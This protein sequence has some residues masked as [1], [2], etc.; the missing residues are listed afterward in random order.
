MRTRVLADVGERFDEIGRRHEEPRLADRAE[1]RYPLSGFERRD[2]LL[3]TARTE[4]EQAEGGKCLRAGASQAELDVARKRALGQGVAFVSVSTSCLHPGQNGRRRCRLG[5]L[6]RLVE[7]PERLARLC[8]RGFPVPGAEVELRPRKERLREVQQE[9]GLT[10]QGDR[11][12]RHLARQ[13]VLLEPD[14]RPRDAERVRVSV[15]CFRRRLHRGER[16]VASSRSSGDGATHAQGH[17]VDEVV[18]AGRKQRQCP[19]DL[20]DRHLRFEAID[21]ELRCEEEQ[22]S[23]TPPVDLD[24]SLRMSGERTVCALEIPLAGAE[25]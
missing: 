20:V 21:T 24:Q 6:P 8:D 15:W 2:R 23:G 14:E 16:G 9:P 18:L 13:L 19:L 17:E 12:I 4:R 3:R 11:T 7:E 10:L 22:R 1:L 5:R 25:I